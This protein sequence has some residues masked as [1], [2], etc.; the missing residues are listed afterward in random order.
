MVAVCDVDDVH[1]AEFNKAFGGKLNTY[2]DYRVMLREEKPDYVAVAWDPRGGSFRREIFEGYKATRDA[3]P[4]D[5][6]VQIPIVRELVDAFQIPVLE[7]KGFEADDVIATLATDLPDDAE[8]LIVSSDK[9]L[10]QLVSNRVTLLDGIKD[11]RYGP[12]DV[13]E[14][15]GV[16]PRCPT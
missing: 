10:M 15:F 13:E 7:V 2:R 14:R 12:V 9:D 5:L 1:A 16:P 4:E 3:Q 11:R 6:T 8:L